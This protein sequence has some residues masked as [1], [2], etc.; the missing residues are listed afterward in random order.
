MRGLLRR[1][2]AVIASA[3]A[4]AAATVLPALTAPASAAGA[5]IIFG[6]AATQGPK[7]NG[8]PAYEKM[9]GVGGKIRP[10]GDAR[11]YYLWDSYKPDPTGKKSI[12]PGKA[13]QWAK[14]NHRPIF[15]SVKAKLRNGSKVT[16]GSIATASPT[17]NVSR[18]KDIVAWAKAV[19]G[20]G[21]P[22]Y[23][24]FNHEPE[25]GASSGMGTPAQYIAAWRNIV[26]IF[27]QQGVTNATYVF[28]ATSYG[29]TRNH[30]N[31]QKYY[32]GDDIVD[33][34]GADVYNWAD[35]RPEV[36]IAWQSLQQMIYPTNVPKSWSKKTG[37][38]ASEYGLVRFGQQHP[39]KKLMLA[40]FGSVEWQDAV[41]PT[42]PSKASWL[43][44]AQ[45]LLKQ[46]AYS[47]FS[48]INIWNS[49]GNGTHS[50]CNF[51]I[52]SSTSALQAMKDWGQDPAFR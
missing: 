20:W 33:A 36:K 5:P 49:E 30:N 18:Y 2:A 51:K 41:T 10:V 16:W 42:S 22:L 9:W 25:A 17:K 26:K 29:F 44:D 48:L 21:Q 3:V 4:V 32:P 37:L 23:F 11:L 7:A 46:P 52:D 35:C 1:R 13:G 50:T 15:M 8:F 45:A 19:K 38:P 28:V 24:T 47:Q 43:R 27:R 40:E 34:I 14:Q 12:F 6:T 31:A 39:S